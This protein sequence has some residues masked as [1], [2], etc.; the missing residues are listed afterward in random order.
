MKTLWEKLYLVFIKKLG[1][2]TAHHYVAVGKEAKIT[3]DGRELVKDQL[4]K[5]DQITNK[6]LEHYKTSSKKYLFA[7]LKDNDKFKT[8]NLKELKKM[9]EFILSNDVSESDPLKAFNIE[10]EQNEPYQNIDKNNSHVEIS[11]E[12]EDYS[13]H[14]PSNTCTECNSKLEIFWGNKYKNYYWHCKNCNKNKSIKVKCP[15]CKSNMRLQKDGNDYNI[16]CPKC[17]IEGFYY[18]AE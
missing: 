10:I 5:Y 9:A 2:Y 12:S 4:L 17:G 6:I 11:E 18:S 16:Y 14:A 13:I 7:D 8:L 3:G 15:S 1:T